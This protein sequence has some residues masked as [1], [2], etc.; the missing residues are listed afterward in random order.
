MRNLRLARQYPRDV[1]PF[2][3]ISDA[4]SAAYADLAAALPV[5]VEARLFRAADEPTPPDW[6]TISS[7]PI[8]QMVADAIEPSRD[9][10][11]G[12]ITALGADDAN[13]ML[14]LAEIAKPGPFGARTY[15]LGQYIGYR[16]SGRLLAMG[17]ERF[18]LPGFAEVSAISVHP[19]ARGRGLGASITLHLARMALARG[20]I[21]FLHVFPENP[22]VALYHRLGFRERARLWVIWRRP[23]AYLR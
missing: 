7:R 16:K 9:P 18:R 23:V 14:E 22:A 17:G 6:Q 21:P 20:D 2:C 3:A 13:A 19:D 8:I 1:A 12:G 4:S 11:L 15:L 10:S 5:D